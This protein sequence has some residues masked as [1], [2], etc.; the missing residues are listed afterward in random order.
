M[1]NSKEIA[2]IIL[3]IIILIFVVNFGILLKDTSFSTAILINS[4]SIIIIILINIFVKKITAEYYQT[5]IEMKIWQF[6]RFGI[7]RYQKF[8]KPIPAGIIFPFIITLASLGYFFFMAVFEF[9]I[10]PTKARASKMH[11]KYRYSELTD[12]HVGLVATAG[13]IAI[14]LSSIIGYIAGFPEFAKLAIYFSAFSLI[15]LSNLD[16]IKIFFAHKTIWMILVVINVIFL[17]YVWLLV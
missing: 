4:V 9:D 7:K 10:K 13:V 15:P 14:L 17:G 2:H 5:Q 16:G 11:G 1:F 6:Q 3:G 8:K 12:I